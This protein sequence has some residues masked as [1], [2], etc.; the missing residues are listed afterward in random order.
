MKA[1]IIGSASDIG[2]YLAE[3]LERD[4]WTVTRW[5]RG[6]AVPLE[7]WDLCV[8]AVGKVA[9][10]GPWWTHEFSEWEEAIESNLL[11]PF[12]MLG[13][14]WP[15]RKTGA[16]VCFMA[17]SNPQKVMRGYSAYNAGKMALL[18]LTEQIDYEA[19]DS[20][21][22]ALNPG[23]IKTK[24]HD[25]TKEARWPNEVI[26]SGREGGSM[27]DVYRALLWCVDQPKE[28][29]GGRNIC[30]SD[31]NRYPSL[32]QLLREDDTLFKLRRVE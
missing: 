4:G 31:F 1:T 20:K 10:V 30:V 29:V 9:P 24:I 32:E 19:K 21:L 15:Y 12:R 8:M 16:S 22:F 3:S 23:Y 26:D 18:K 13:Y 11:L 28:V 27:E 25:A 2:A 17:G 5:K 6:D 7:Q 14:L